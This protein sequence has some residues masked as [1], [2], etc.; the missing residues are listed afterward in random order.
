MN[1]NI[2][3]HLFGLLSLGALRGHNLLPRY[4]FL[5]PLYRGY[6]KL[7]GIL[8]PESVVVHGMVMYIGDDTVEHARLGESYE[9]ETTDAF[10]KY[11]RPGDTVIDVGANIGYFT[12]LA[13]TLVGPK[14]R[15]FSFEPCREHFLLLEKNITRNHLS[16]VKIFQQG[17]SDVKGRGEVVGDVVRPGDAIDLVPLDDVMTGSVNFVKIDI[18]GGEVRALRGMRRILIE[19]PDIILVAEFNEPALSSMGFEPHELLDT[20]REAGFSTEVLGRPEDQGVKNLLCM[21][22][23]RA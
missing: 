2:R 10:K 18:E 3:G 7:Y 16:N 23:A 15:V 12:L 11:I 5:R 19:N 8:K 6:Q 13:A 14:G 4:P 20:L 9:K 22:A 21:R 17:V 1:K